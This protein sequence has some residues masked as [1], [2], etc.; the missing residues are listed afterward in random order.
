MR[1]FRDAKAMTTALR[2][3]LAAKDLT[4]T[5]SE[6]L[7]L[8]AKAFNFDNWNIL[9]AKIEAERPPARRPPLPVRRP[10]TARSAASRSRR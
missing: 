4:V 1:D 7:E 10:C 5:H 8:I 2:Q 3:A 6:A 9:A